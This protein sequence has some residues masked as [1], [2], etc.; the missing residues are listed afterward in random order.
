MAVTRRE[1]IS[2]A[3]AGAAGLAV[4]GVVGRIAGGGGETEGGG[5]AVSGVSSDV[6]AIAEARGL[7]PDNVARA[8]KTFVPPGEHLDEFFI[9]ASGGLSHTKIDE[10]LDEGFIKALQQNNLDY[11]GAMRA[12]DLVEGTSEIRNW[13]VSAAAADQ[14]GTMLDYFP[15]YRT[16][17]GVGCAMGFAHWDLN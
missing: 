5:G 3:A 10:R 2:G 1:F 6:N 7:T 14:P 9:I 13:I 11:M 4:G 17:T 16:N 12:S 8:V 15:L